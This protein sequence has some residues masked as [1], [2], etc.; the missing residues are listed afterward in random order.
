MQHTV[1]V[2]GN[3][4]TSRVFLL[5]SLLSANLVAIY[6]FMFHGGSVIQA[7]WIY[8]LQS[9]I[10]GAVNVARLLSY[11]LDYSGLAVNGKPI[12][13][14]SVAAERAVR[15][16]MTGFFI[17]HYGSFHFAYMIFLIAFSFPDLPL[18][19]DGV[20][21]KLNFG[22]L[23]VG[24][25]I[26]GGLVFAAHHMLSFVEERNELQSR[27]AIF[28]AASAMFRPYIRVIPMHLIIVAGPFV[29][30]AAGSAAVFL[31]FMILKTAA[32]LAL[33]FGSA[34][35]PKSIQTTTLPR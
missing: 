34:S 30:G 33:Y 25:L 15:L 8:W 29:A 26:L 5:A 35:R 12:V 31:V 9:V 17:L 28:S 13:V 32:D 22:T 16:S 3:F 7:L 23:N 24:A 21:A 18:T 11:K 10:I 14:D 2:S 27:Q 4:W 20:E 6:F 1:H 19:I